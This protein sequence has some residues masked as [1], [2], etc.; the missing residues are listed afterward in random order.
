M[1]L[2]RLILDYL[3]DIRFAVRQYRR[4]PGFTL[5]A[6]LTLAFGI[7][8]TTA[9]YTVVHA[10]LLRPLPF[11]DSDSL[12]MAWDNAPQDGDRFK[13]IMAS[14]EDIREYARSSTLERIASA[15]RIRPVLHRGDLARRTVAGLVTVGMFRD[16][17]GSKAWLGR[18]FVDEDQQAGCVVVL[19][20]RF[21]SRV[22]DGDASL[23]GRTLRFDETGCAVVGVMPLGFDL[24]P[25]EAEM[26]FLRDH[27]PAAA[28]ETVRRGGYLDR[29]IV[30][31]RLKPGAT[32]AQAE[33]ELTGLHRNLY[34]TGPSLDPNHGGERERVVAVT[35]VR[36]A[37]MGVISPSLD[38][39]LWLAF[40]SV[41]LLLL[42]ACVNVANLLLARLPDRQ[43]ELVVRSALG[44]GRARLVRQMLTEGTVLAGAGTV[45]GVAL[46]WA[47]VRWF[48][49]LSPFP[50]PTQTGEVSLNLRVLLFAMGISFPTTL[51]FTLLPALAGSKL[52]LSQSLRSAGRGFFGSAGRR[53]TSQ[54][55]VA[56]EMA[57]SF[58]LLAAAGLL[59]SSVVRLEREQLGF[60][61][62]GIAR[63]SGELPGNRYPTKESRDAF[64]RAL[65]E[66]VEALPGVSQVVFGGF[67]PSSDGGQLQIEVQGRPVE[68]V[69]DV[70]VIPASRE[71]F[72]LL[73]VP[74]LRGRNFTDADQT[75]PALA[76]VSQR[77]VDEY[78]K[79]G[80]AI[81]RSI[82]VVDGDTRGEWR[83]IVGV[84]GTW[85]HMVD[86][87]AWRDTPVVF[88]IGGAPK[89]IS[90][91]Y[92]LGIAVRTGGD[93]G[94]AATELQRQISALEPNAILQD[95]EVP[96]Q[97]LNAMLS[98]PRFRAELLVAFSVGAL[99]LAAVGL[100]GVI[101]QLVAQRMPE[102]GV[103]R[104]VG[105]QTRD[106][107]WLVVRQGGVGV[108]LGL[109]A[110]LAGAFAT[111]RLIKG[112]LY[113]VEIGDARSLVTATFVLIMSAALGM[114]LP[115][116]RAARVD[117]MAAL[118]Q[119]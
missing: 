41:V 73:R 54:M 89:N 6:V 115:A 8:A 30:Y 65:R 59:M 81:G 76:I 113:G 92:G 84:V 3:K 98:Y 14:P 23:V 37:V 83:T 40:G 95:P 45:L 94:L 93:A 90:E 32:P 2:Q 9:V 26:W 33:V 71:Y 78:L 42:I 82:R 19:A 108:A 24:F 12:V 75:G 67:P 49:Y 86:N 5:L 70:D 43:R 7:G 22:L 62:A 27:A 51:L 74:I 10:V 17:L 77:F 100:Y 68:P 35:P 46:A 28:I 61:V 112:M 80:D 99:L 102:F 47:G 56:V 15:A 25:I 11:A 53:R 91:G 117:P 87:T 34:A 1:A 88:S 96:A 105:A 119:E 85:K 21:W 116:L 103:R 58:V 38:T 39:S 72:E 107:V 31:A 118:R 13:A 69:F 111:G 64:E 48:R 104:A 44:S 97:R 50:L 109:I 57:L 79:D 36:S 18:V 63:A 52:D 20:Y 60:D 110:G 4:Y 55:M 114:V 101:A 29:G 16:T 106:L 66:R